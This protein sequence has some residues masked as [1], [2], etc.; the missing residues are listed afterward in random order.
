MT[1]PMIT[2]TCITAAVV[3]YFM[4]KLFIAVH[5]SRQHAHVHARTHVRRHPFFELGTEREELFV[6]G[7][8][9]H[10]DDDCDEDVI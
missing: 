3:L 10:V 4:V 6:G 1:T 5:H 9:M 8:P 2:W 7:D